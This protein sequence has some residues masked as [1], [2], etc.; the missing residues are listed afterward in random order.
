MSVRLN[1]DL[2]IIISVIESSLDRTDDLK[3]LTSAFTPTMWDDP[4]YNWIFETLIQPHGNNCV[5]NHP[6]GKQLGGSSAI[7]FNY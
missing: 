3:V 5:V 6:R 4:D 1:E 2:N 7:D